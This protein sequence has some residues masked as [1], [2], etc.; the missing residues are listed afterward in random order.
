MSS[1][2]YVNNKTLFEALIEYKKK[3]SEAKANDLPKP[4]I[5]N[6]IGECFV[7]IANRLSTK[8]NFVNYTYRDEMI[9]DALENCI[10]VVDNFD[11]EKSSNP[12]A[13]FTQI[14]HFA[15][16]RRILKEKKHLYIKYKTMQNAYLTGALSHKQEVD[17]LKEV[18]SSYLDNEY[19]N[20]LVKQYEITVEEKRVKSKLKKKGLEKFIEE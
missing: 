3:V 15:F 17:E 13:Y 18:D 2:H 8:P 4:R 10:S 6:Y 5:P 20:N 19:M 11:P 16:L 9:S 7:Q 12:F 14:I 1:K